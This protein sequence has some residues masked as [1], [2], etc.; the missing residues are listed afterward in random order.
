MEDIIN[1]ESAEFVTVV[2]TTGDDLTESVDSEG[3]LF[4]S[5]QCRDLHAA[6]THWGTY[7]PMSKVLG[8]LIDFDMGLNLALA[9]DEIDDNINT[10]EGTYHFGTI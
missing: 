9:Y 1:T 10:L 7:L 8:T 6:A 2:I 5:I 3:S 4:D